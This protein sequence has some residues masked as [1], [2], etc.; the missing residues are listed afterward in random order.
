MLVMSDLL[1]VGDFSGLD[2]TPP[3]PHTPT[4]IGCSPSFF[5]GGYGVRIDPLGWSIEKTNSRTNSHT[6][7]SK[8]F[9]TSTLL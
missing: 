4:E 2:Y 5:G 3:P 7:I 1:G 9:A 6:A 8:H